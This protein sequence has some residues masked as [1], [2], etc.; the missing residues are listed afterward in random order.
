VAERW[1]VERKH[2]RLRRE[3]SSVVVGRRKKQKQVF[4]PLI[5]GW[6][7][8]IIIFWARHF[9][10]PSLVEL[11]APHQRYTLVVVDYYS[12]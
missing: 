5:G 9:G 2:K 4:F 11:F 1:E 10:R 8:A 7:L 12:K 3:R 6:V